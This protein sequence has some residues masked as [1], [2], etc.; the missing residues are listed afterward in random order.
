MSFTHPEGGSI[1]GLRGFDYKLFEE[2]EGGGE[3]RGT[4]RVVARWL[5]KIDGKMNEAVCMKNRFKS[6]GG[7]NGQLNLSKGKS[8]GNVLVV[9]Y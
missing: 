5:V 6:N 8:S 9:F 4:R 3:T 2:M 1:I 7:G